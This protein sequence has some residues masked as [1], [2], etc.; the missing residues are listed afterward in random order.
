MPLAE[1]GP[2]EVMR[3]EQKAIIDR[4]KIAAHNAE[5]WLLERLAHHY[6]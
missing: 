4:I 5:E 2:R 3:L 1:A 6:Q